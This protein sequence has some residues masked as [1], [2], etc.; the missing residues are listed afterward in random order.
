MVHGNRFLLHPRHPG[1]SGHPHGSQYGGESQQGKIHPVADD[2]E[3]F[4]LLLPQAEQNQQIQEARHVRRQ[5][6]E[7]EQEKHGEQPCGRQ[8]DAF[9]QNRGEKHGAAEQM[10]QMEFERRHRQKDGEQ[11]LPAPFQPKRQNG[12]AENVNRQQCS[13]NQY[14]VESLTVISSLQNQP[15][16]LLISDAPERTARFCRKE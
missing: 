3:P 1:S 2:A 8:Q 11:G 5:Q 4:R 16:N 12:A 7:K 6:Q 9:R 14:H 13:E 10:Q 15:Q